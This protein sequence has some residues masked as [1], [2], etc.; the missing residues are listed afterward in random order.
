VLTT[1]ISEVQEPA[2]DLRVVLAQEW[3][4]G[5][6]VGEADGGCRESPTCGPRP[7]R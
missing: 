3:S 6:L 1:L 7:P 5:H 4:A 2:V